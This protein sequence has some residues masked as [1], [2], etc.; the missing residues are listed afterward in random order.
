MGTGS[1][2]GGAKSHV[3]I[4][5]YYIM[6]GKFIGMDAES[7]FGARGKK[8]KGQFHQEEGFFSYDEDRKLII[9]RQLSS[10]GYVNQYYLNDTISTPHT[11]VFD[12][13][14]TE[15]FVPDGRARWIIQKEGDH[16]LSTSFNV[17]FP[18]QDFVSF[19]MQ[20]LRKNP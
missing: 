19:G 14:R 2:Y 16:Q 18:K 8:R 15:N 10:D 6:Q 3:E 17:A 5:F 20:E 12:T 9:Y 11:L 1:G 13:E 7:R 4:S